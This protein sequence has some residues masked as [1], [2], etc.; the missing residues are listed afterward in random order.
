M[1]VREIDG[2]VSAHSYPAPWSLGTITVRSA[3]STTVH[4]TPQD[5]L[6]AQIG[7]ETRAAPGSRRWT[8]PHVGAHRQAQ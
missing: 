8:S 4:R 5:V 6:Y 7:A 3:S 2:S 1:T